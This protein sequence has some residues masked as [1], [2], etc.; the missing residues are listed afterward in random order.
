MCGLETIQLHNTVVSG[1]PQRV[2]EA[3]D[4]DRVRSTN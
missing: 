2:I 3:L 1:A 4:A